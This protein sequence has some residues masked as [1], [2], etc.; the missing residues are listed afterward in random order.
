VRRDVKLA[1]FDLALAIENARLTERNRAVLE[2][3]LQVA[4]SRYAVGQTSQADVLKA[5]T[6]VAKMSDE[7]IKLARERRMA[8]AELNRAMGRSPERAA[9]LPQMP[10]LSEAVLSLDALRGAA[11]RDRPQL[12]AQQSVIA[13]NSKALELARKEYYPD[14]EVRLSYGQRDR[15]LTGERR[16]DMVSLTLGVSLPVWRGAKLDP[17]VRE[18]AAM[19]D[20]A[21]SMYQSQANEVAARLRQTVATA[22]QNLRSAQLYRSS[23]LPQ[24]QLTVESAL[25]AYKVNRVD[26]MTLL[27]N[28][29]T[30]LNY[31]ISYATSVVSHNKALAEI[32]FITGKAM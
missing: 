26:L 1:Y 17:R 8:E 24:A 13:K 15:M 23:I 22:E 11:L 7:L 5:Q 25:S 6:Q 31:E 29:M 32:E 20:Q 16:D 28:Q 18:A 14:F 19:R 10:G 9:P 30:V 21:L 4:Q 27:D 12:L 2:Q 3:L